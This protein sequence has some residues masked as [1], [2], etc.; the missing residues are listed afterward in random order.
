MADRA[1]RADLAGAFGVLPHRTPST[2]AAL[3][4]RLRFAL[5]LTGGL[6][7]T[8]ATPA[9]SFAQTPPVIERPVPFDAGGRVPALT[10]TLVARLQLAAPAWPVTGSFRDA[11]LYRV[12]G[13]GHV[14]V[15]TRPDGAVAR[16]PLDSA[17][18]ATLQRAVETALLAE[19]PGRGRQTD[20]ATGL[21]VSQPAGN[22]FVRNQTLL[23]L[24]A[25]GPAAAALLSDNGAAA[26]VGGY[27]LAAGTS[28]FVAANT[29]RNG[30]VT[31]AQAARA[32]HG[33]TRGAAAGA[34]VAAM[35]RA[36][37]GPAWGA[38]ILTGAVGGTVL[39][40]RHG[41]G[42]SDGEAASAGLGA[43]LLALTTL[44][45]GGAAGLFKPVERD[46]AV[47]PERPE[48]GTYRES[49][50]SLRGPGKAVMGGA[51]AAGAFGYLIGPRYARRA[52]Y[53]V[54]AGDVSV[55]F[56]GALAGAV[57]AS[58]FV[59]E[60]GGE[61]A[62]YGAATAGLVAGA[63]VSDRVLV[64]RAD[65]TAADGALAQLGAVAGGL[66]GG[67]VAAMATAGRQPSVALVAAGGALGLLAA[68]RILAPAPDAGP[69]R[70]VMHGAARRLDG[71][72][73]V[74]LGP[75]SSVRVSF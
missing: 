28:F 58:A 69:L 67:G 59:P 70:G 12:E 51:V 18:L 46:V 25:Y 45:A 24:V 47:T 1:E 29:V 60:G 5:L 55:A 71:R 10:P 44:G 35:A 54:T 65:R 17:A 7:M 41:R 26:A 49:D 68:D 15:V 57:A 43:D 74:A 16:F 64:R 34:A 22:T 72:L 33:G 53:N 40:Y 36:D 8:A 19:A 14:L 3:A 6:A 13:N 30:T 32:G 66:I 52:A 50:R 61:Q 2:P 62:A 56:A 11:R 63:L 39:G 37:G 4:M 75:V 27:F 48:F 73:H 31:R 20:A 23:G 38:A 9:R 42:L 21:E